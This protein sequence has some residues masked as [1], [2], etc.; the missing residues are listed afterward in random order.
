MNAI[1]IFFLFIKKCFRFI[2]FITIE[3]HLLIVYL[4][5]HVFCLTP[6]FFGD[7]FHTFTEATLSSIAKQFSWALL[8]HCNAI[9]FAAFTL[10]KWPLSKCTL[11]A[12]LC[13]SVL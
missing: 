9:Y 2:G 1:S 8:F 3:M 13:Q 6:Y 11:K 10:I 7:V 12:K 4:T 5:L